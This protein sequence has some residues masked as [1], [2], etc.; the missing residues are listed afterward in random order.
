M[1]KIYSE[2]QNKCKLAKASPETIKFLLGYSK[3]LQII[4]YNNVQF[5]NN[6][7]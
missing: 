4:E 3:S 2:H 5:E 1:E 6:L 7:N